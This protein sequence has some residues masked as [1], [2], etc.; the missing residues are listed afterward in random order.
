MS[1]YSHS[2][3][4]KPKAGYPWYEIIVDHSLQ[5]GDIIED[6]PVHY[7]LREDIEKSLGRV[8]QYDLIVMTQSCD[9]PKATITHLVLC[10]LFTFEQIEPF[11]PQIRNAGTKEKVRRGDVTSLHLLNECLEP[12]LNRPFRVVNFRRLFE[13]SKAEL[14]GFVAAKKRIRLL[15][16][17]REHLS[18][19]FARFFMR[20]G[21]PADIP[22]FI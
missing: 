10:P 16:P 22:P 12:D 13:T 5:Q 15:P 1:Y 18:Q 11:W 6:Y 8:D 3:R 21:L 7:S 4:G 17:Y 19:A 14:Q 2:N 9:I 20:V